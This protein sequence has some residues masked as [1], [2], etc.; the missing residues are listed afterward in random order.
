MPGRPTGGKAGVAGFAE[1]LERDRIGAPLGL[2]LLLGLPALGGLLA[3]IARGGPA[4]LYGIA[5]FTGLAVLGLAAVAVLLHLA[6]AVPPRRA[7]RVVQAAVF[8][9]VPGAIVAV[10]FPW[11][12][13]VLAPA[14]I[15]LVLAAVYVRARGGGTNLAVTAGAGAFGLVAG[16]SLLPSPVCGPLDPGA[17]A[18]DVTVATLSGLG[19]LGLGLFL[20]DRARPRVVPFLTGA[21]GV[22]HISLPI[23]GAVLGILLGTSLEVSRPTDLPLVLV[24]L[25]SAVLAW[26]TAILLRDAWDPR[27]ASTAALNP[28]ERQAIALAASPVPVALAA[29]L[30]PAPMLVVATLGAISWATAWGLR[31]QEEFLKNVPFL[32]A[33]FFVLVGY[34]AV[35]PAGISEATTGACSGGEATC[36]LPLAG[37]DVLFPNSSPGLNLPL[38]LLAVLLTLL[39]LVV[40]RLWTRSARTAPTSEQA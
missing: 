2:A 40:T 23:I 14:G 9:V 12:A 7:V 1:A 38:S 34:F 15:A 35:N 3:A 22:P 6:A 39:P 37:V 28:I 13:S 19:A 31:L 4:S 10:F 5:R 30:G 16:L 8:L 18:V 21:P 27:G 20:L 29:L 36:L 33:L 24:V 11:P 25:A 32:Y 17:C 26:I